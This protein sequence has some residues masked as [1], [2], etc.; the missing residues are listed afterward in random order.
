MASLPGGGVFPVVFV[1]PHP[2]RP[3]AAPKEEIRIQLEARMGSLLQFADGD[4]PR[5]NSG[6]KLKAD[7]RDERKGSKRNKERRT[8]GL[9]QA[10]WPAIPANR[11]SRRYS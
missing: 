6:Q 1:Y 5:R 3:A 9:A 2:A 8:S 4:T 11:A 7:R 10:L